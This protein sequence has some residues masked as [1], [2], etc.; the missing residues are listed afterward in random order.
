M[1]DDGAEQVREKCA[2]VVI[3]HAEEAFF[4]VEEVRHGAV[5]A[6]QALVGQG[7]DDPAAVVGGAVARD[8][9]VGF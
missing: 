7:D 8:Q 6:A 1:P 9:A 2:V 4:D 3:D 5:H